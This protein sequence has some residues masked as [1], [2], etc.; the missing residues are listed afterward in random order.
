MITLNPVTDKEIKKVLEN[1]KNSHDIDLPNDRIMDIV[2]SCGKDLRHAIATLELYSK[3]HS[4][5]LRPLEDSN[6][7]FGQ[8]KNKGNK[9]K[10]AKRRINMSQ[11][12]FFASDKKK[13]TDPAK[14]KNQDQKD[15]GLTIFRALGK[16]LYNKRI[17][18][19]TNEARAMTYEELSQS[20]KPKFYESHKEILE[21]VQTETHTF[22]LFLQENMYDFCTDISDIANILDVYSCNDSIQ[23]PTVYSY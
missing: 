8:F 10:K 9:G 3:G 13:P 11:Q 20:P 21:N 12:E 16:F 4:N 14:V 22:S 17:D 6:T 19:L 2:N 5:I 7:E 15:Y 1:I 18:P 23:N